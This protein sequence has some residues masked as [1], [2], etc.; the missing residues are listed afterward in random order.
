MKTNSTGRAS[1]ERNTY[2]CQIGKLTL[3]ALM[4]ASPRERANTANT[5]AKIARGK[6]SADVVEFDRLINKSY[7]DS[8]IGATLIMIS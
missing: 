7:V 4:T 8:M 3:I 1:A 6:L 2:S 5:I